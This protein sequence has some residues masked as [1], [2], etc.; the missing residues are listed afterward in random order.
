MRRR[1]TRGQALVEFALVFPIFILVVMFMADF[2]RA[3]FSYNSITNAVREAAR[4]GIVNQDRTSITNRAIFQ[5]A[6]GETGA[7]NVTVQFKE[8]L[9]NVDPATNA[10]C[11]RDNRGNARL[12]EVG[13]VVI[14][15]FQTTYTPI[16]PFVGRIL[17]AGGVTL[18][19][20]SIEAIE[21]VCPNANVAA[22]NCPKQP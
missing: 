2:G 9:P 22:A 3:V 18:T 11:D 6:V 5:T 14:V 4:L 17:F 10:D 7:P 12:P 8:S 15:T 20:K 1:R 21:F 16:T 13:C 19:A